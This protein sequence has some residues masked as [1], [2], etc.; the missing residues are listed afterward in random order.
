MRR[1]IFMVAV[2]AAMSC[3]GQ[4]KAGNEAAAGGNAAESAA[5]DVSLQPGLWEMRSQGAPPQTTTDPVDGSPSTL[6]HQVT[7]WCMD[8]AAAR[9]PDLEQVAYTHTVSTGDCSEEVSFAA[10]RI[11]GAR[12]C[13]NINGVVGSRSTFTGQYTPTTYEILELRR[14]VSGGG[15]GEPGRIRSSGRRIGDCSEENMLNAMN[16]DEPR[17]Q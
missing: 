5:A 7:R 4:N 2:L 17:N 9:R 12:E 8:E 14:D 6:R 15:A 11:E 10:G 13:R 1:P 3:S 16:A